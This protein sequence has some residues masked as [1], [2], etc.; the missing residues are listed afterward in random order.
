MIFFNSKGATKKVRNLA[1]DI[2]S[3]TKDNLFPRMNN[4]DLTL[5]LVPGLLYK[6]GVFGDCEHIDDRTFTIR[7]DPHI[8]MSEFVATL[9]HEMVHVRQYAR[10]ELYEYARDPSTT[11]FRTKKYYTNMSYKNRP[12]ETEAHRLEKELGDSYVTTRGF[13]YCN[14]KVENCLKINKQKGLQIK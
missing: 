10:K 3:F 9:C 4:L 14:Y 1:E 12:W 8:K 6:E 5:E 2:C 13:K 11:R 7:I